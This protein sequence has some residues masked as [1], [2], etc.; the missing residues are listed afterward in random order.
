VS[1]K[2]RQDACITFFVALF[3]IVGTAF[4]GCAQKPLKAPESTAVEGGFRNIESSVSTAE[5][6]R[7]TIAAEN[8]KARANLERIND[9]NVIAT[10]YREYRAKHPRPTPA[11]TP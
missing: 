11:P 7:K 1:D 3:M 9:K 8:A 6:Q 2:F 5:D 10:R 4:S